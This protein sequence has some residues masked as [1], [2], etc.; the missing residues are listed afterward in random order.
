[1]RVPAGPHAPPHPAAPLP[2][3]LKFE[4]AL[5]R[6]K[7]AV[8]SVREPQVG[9]RGSGRAASSSRRSLSRMHVNR[10]TRECLTTAGADH[11]LRHV[12]PLWLCRRWRTAA[13]RPES[14]PRSPR[15]GAWAEGVL[16]PAAGRRSTARCGGAC[17]PPPTG[18][19]RTLLVVGLGRVSGTPQTSAHTAGHL[20]GRRAECSGDAALL[21]CG[22]GGGQRAVCA[23]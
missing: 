19:A 16:L 10:Q 18:T 22:G 4:K 13:R 7:G 9:G 8:Q 23:V 6:A 21:S 1:M 11:L 17:M 14:R 3:R 20:S 12:F 15:A 5:V 2:P